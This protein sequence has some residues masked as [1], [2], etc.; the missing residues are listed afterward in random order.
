MH[1]RSY[2]FV[3]ADRPERFA[4][5]L[6]SGADAVIVDLEDAVAPQ[7]K[8]TARAALAEWLA[9]GGGPVALRI[10]GVQTEWFADELA[11]L[12][13]AAPAAALLPLVESAAGIANLRQLAGADGVQRL[14]FGSIDLQ[15]DLGIHGEGEELLMFRSQL[16]LASR[17]A[18]LAPP[19]DGVCTAIDAPDLLLADAQRARRL[20]FG[21]KLC[22][23]PRQVAVVNRAFSPTPE[24]LAWARR[25]VAAAAAAH[26]GAVAVD[27]RMVDRPVL[28]RAEALLAV[29]RQGGA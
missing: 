23:H 25:V 4:K 7:A 26:G 24:E 17:L 28:S 19:V 9:G 18:G 13:A 6:A 20:G 11:R 21:A 15:L 3:P 5:A 12:R 14:L 29:A 16:V 27:G 22:I 1:A 8:A 10:K 2:L